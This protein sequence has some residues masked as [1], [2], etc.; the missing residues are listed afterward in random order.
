MVSEVVADGSETNI[1]T[2]VDADHV[3]NNQ[4]MSDTKLLQSILDKISSVDKKVDNG[5]KNV[6]KRFDKVDKRIDKLGL[7]LAEL[8]DDAPTIE[9]HDDLEKRVG[10]LEKQTASV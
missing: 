10:N 4:N 3:C 8:A 7:Q 2:I 9:E 6:K 5:F 1:L